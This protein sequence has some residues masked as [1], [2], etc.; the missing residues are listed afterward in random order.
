[1]SAPGLLCRCSICGQEE[2]TGAN[3]LKDGWPKCCGY[4]MTLI[5]T[6]RFINGIESAMEEIMAPRLSRPEGR[7]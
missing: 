4:T 3:P 1:M 5:E 7:P 6:Q 2:R